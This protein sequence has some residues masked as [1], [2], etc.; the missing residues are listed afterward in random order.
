MMILRAHGFFAHFK[1]RRSEWLLAFVAFG[2]G[3]AYLS[4]P[5][6]FD[7]QIFQ[8]MRAIG[9]QAAWGAAVTLV[10]LVRLAMLW[11]NGAW[12]ISPYFR[13]IGA[14]VCTGLWFMLFVSQ[15]IGEH[16]PQTR[17][18]WLICLVFDLLNAG[19]AAFDAGVASTRPAGRD[20][21]R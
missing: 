11:I 13:A 14:F 19:D 5:G 9:S 17:W 15:S 12:R 2:I 1:A 4:Q 10:A 7:A 6:L 8:R 21:A 18:V 3:M 20:H 16:P